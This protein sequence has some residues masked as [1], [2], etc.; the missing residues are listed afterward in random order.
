[1]TVTSM[2]PIEK[3][4]CLIDLHL[5]F[6]GSLSVKLV[7]ELAAMQGISLPADEDRKSVV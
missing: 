6:D 1:M 7:K 2:F 4:D 3:L 5:H